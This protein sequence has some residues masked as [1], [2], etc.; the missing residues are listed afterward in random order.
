MLVFSKDL[1]SSNLAFHFVKLEKE[2]R[3]E[4]EANRRKEV[5]HI[6]TKIN[7]LEDGKAIEKIS[8]TK[9]SSEISTNP[10]LD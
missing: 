10:E 4:P 5:T 6:R 3:S 9:S 8:E 1:K 2:E 7:E